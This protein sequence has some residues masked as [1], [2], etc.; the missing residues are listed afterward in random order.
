[1]RTTPEI[2]I[3]NIIEDY[4]PDAHPISGDSAYMYTLKSSVQSL[5]EIDRRIILLYA[6]C[7]SM[8]RLGKY[9]GVSTSTAYNEIK[10]IQKIIKQY[11]IDHKYDY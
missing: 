8:R 1:M 10:R 7:G 6:D 2:N 3:N 4:L 5:T 9:L 11:M